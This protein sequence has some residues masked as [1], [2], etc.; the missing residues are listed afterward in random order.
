[1][2]SVRSRTLDDTHRSDNKSRQP[3][4]ISVSPASAG[5]LKNSFR[6]LDEPFGAAGRKPNADLNELRLPFQT[7]L[8]PKRKKAKPKYNPLPP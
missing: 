6:H 7:D 3:S 8:Q 2:A 4:H 1:M 5:S